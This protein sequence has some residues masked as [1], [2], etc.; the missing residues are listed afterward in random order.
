[1]KEKDFNIK[2]SIE[3]TDLHSKGAWEV[4]GEYG[5]YKT[6][7]LPSGEKA[8]I[9][10][11]CVVPIDYLNRDN[12]AKTNQMGKFRQVV[13][14][15]VLSDG[16]S[17][18]IV[19]KSP[20]RVLTKEPRCLEK[21]YPFWGGDRSGQKYTYIVGNP[22]VEEQVVWEAAILLELLRLGIKAERP[23]A[24]IEGINGARELVVNK[25]PVHVGNPGSIK[26][27]GPTEQEIRDHLKA[28]S[29]LVPDDLAPHNLL[30]DTNGYTHVIDVNRWAFLPHT[31][32]F[33]KCLIEIIAQSD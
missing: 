3:I 21:G 20:E 25:I 32:H 33:R 27:R 2:N 1:M 6:Y 5:V 10:P 28:N 30:R 15:Q 11:T 22:V 13:A 4:L 24:I 14:V 29:P 18:E 12:W 19:V 8:T 17:P 16:V 26:L 23:L 7:V 9:L 31:D